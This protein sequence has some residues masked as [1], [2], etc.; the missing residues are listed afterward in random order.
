MKNKATFRI[1]LFALGLSVLLGACGGKVPAD[2]P[3]GT[4]DATKPPEPV[5]V[6]I[7]AHSGALT[8]EELQRY[9][10]EPVGK[11][12]PHIT[13]KRVDT[14]VKGQTIHELVAAG[15]IPDIVADYPLAITN[16]T[17]LGI[18][19]N[20]E[21]LIRSNTFDLN[22]LR[23]EFLDSIKNVSGLNH[24]IGLPI[25]NNAF[26]LFYNK[27][28][29]DRAGIAYPKDLITW[30]ETAS[31]AAR[32]TKTEGGTEYRGLYPGGL[33]R[34]AYQ[35]GLPFIDVKTDKAVYQTEGWK[36]LLQLWER[37][38]KAQ[39]GEVPADVLSESA[40]PFT[41]GRVAMYPGHGGSLQTM[42]KAEGLNW[43]L[44]TYPI[45]PKAP[46]TGQRVDSLVWSVTNQSQ[47]KTAAFQVIAE[48]LSDEVQMD[49]SR[50]SKM[51]V[52]K[53]E[54]IQQEFGK[55]TA[56]L[57]NKNLTAFTKL[58]LAVIQPFK[59]NFSPNPASLIN[60]KMNDVLLKGKDINTALREADEE[61]N[62]QIQQIKSK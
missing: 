9:V 4:P 37:L 20:M 47:A 61:L 3:S 51:S 33:F 56:A 25:F 38:V 29:F 24:L 19:Y 36:E 32:L 5:T 7:S 55:A 16:L 30:D 62:L 54:A 8:E 57:V 52:L 17:D 26:A 13:V 59:Y 2:N 28:L 23:P 41:A 48:L 58:K 11:K 10:I 45:N 49:I 43:D 50:N 44:T 60:T 18:A 12:Y 31:L 22:R 21:E 14:A 6:T 40:T 34:G 27:D 53:K 42:L 39:G 15:T 1:S 46:G 35:L